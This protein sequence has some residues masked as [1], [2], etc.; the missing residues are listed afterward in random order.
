LGKELLLHVIERI[1]MAKTVDDVVVITTS[2]PE[3]PIVDLCI[4]A[5]I[6]YYKGSETDLLDRHYQ[7]TKLYD[8]DFVVKV[9]LDCPLSDHRVVDEVISLWKEYQDS[10][11]YVSNYHPP[12][13]PDGLDISLCLLSLV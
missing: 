9:P 5:G 10:Y 6:K 8:A 13:F 12:T 11:D 1:E 3:N 4:N 7:A 2:T